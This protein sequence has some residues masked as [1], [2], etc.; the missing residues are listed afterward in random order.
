M[1]HHHHKRFRYALRG[2]KTV[3]R[4]E[5]SFRFQASVFLI[6]VLLG[7]L[8][9]LSRLEWAAIL[10]VSAAVLVLECGNSALERLVDAVEPRLHGTV[11]AIKDILAGAVLIMSLVAVAV[12]VIIFVPHF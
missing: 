9:R 1:L 6:V 7:G 4:E 12:G 11:A 8:V 3:L 2:I 10:I 5:A